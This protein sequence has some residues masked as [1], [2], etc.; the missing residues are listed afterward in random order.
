[1]VGAIITH[2]T[3]LHSSP[4]MPIVLLVICA[5]VFVLRRDRLAVGAGRRLA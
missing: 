1:M 3:I 5:I 4:A 2:L